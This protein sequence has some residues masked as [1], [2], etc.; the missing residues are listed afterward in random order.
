MGVDAAAQS[1]D[2]VRPHPSR[3]L[4]RLSIAAAISA[5]WYGLYR[6][7]YGLGGTYGMF[8]VPAS[9]EQWRA[10]NLVAAGL[11]LGAAA[12]PLV[13]LPLWSRPLPRRL[14]L[15]IAWVIAVACIGHALIDDVLRVLSLAGRYGV[16]YPAEVW[17]SVDRRAADLQDLLFN[18]TWFLLEGA[19][20]L[21]IGWTVIGPT[22]AR[23]WW[24]GSAVVAIGLATVVGI[25]SGFGVLGRTVIG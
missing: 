23:R 12:L 5:L 22:R 25:L 24:I 21:A 15:G 14:L 13:A 17:I 20:W 8:G 9:A 10:I 4:T 3:R 18:E 2:V 6:A 19:L 16:S 7:Y 11:L 1:R